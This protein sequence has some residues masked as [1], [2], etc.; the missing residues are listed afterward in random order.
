MSILFSKAKMG[1]FVKGVLESDPDDGIEITQATYDSLKE[2]LSSGQVLSTDKK[3]R[4]IA[5]DVVPT[6]A[7]YE[8][9]VARNKAGLL[10]VATTHIA[11]LQDAVDLS[12]ATDDEKAL[13]VKWKEYRVA[14]NRVQE[15]SGYPSII[16]WPSTPV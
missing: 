15:Q 6:K 5:V 1:F 11:P 3:G 8:V 2:K 12:V 9:A 16:E 13:L 4:P 14:L 10:A 7:Q